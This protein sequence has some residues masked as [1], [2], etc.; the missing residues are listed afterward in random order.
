MLLNSGSCCR[1]DYIAVSFIVV[2][3]HAYGTLKVVVSKRSGIQNFYYVVI[4][5]IFSLN[6]TLPPN[7]WHVTPLEKLITFCTL[8][9]HKCSQCTPDGFS[10]VNEGHF[11]LFSSI[12]S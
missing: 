12:V 5:L 10:K 4:M 7:V 2:S 3:F 9:M 11:N 8:E 6:P 1:V